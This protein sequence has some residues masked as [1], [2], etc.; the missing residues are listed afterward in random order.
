[1][2]ETT[3]LFRPDGIVLQYMSKEAPTTEESTT[4]PEET[5]EAT[6]T[7]ANPLIEKLKELKESDGFVRNVVIVGAAV[8]L[9]IVAAIVLRKK[10]KKTL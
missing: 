4:A 3:T 10:A 6:P 8:V 7:D 5:T 9:V 2:I 1:M